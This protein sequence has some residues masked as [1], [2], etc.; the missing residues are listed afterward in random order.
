MKKKFLIP[1]AS[2]LLSASLGSGCYYDVESEL[3]GMNCDTATVSYGTTVNTIINSYGCLSCHSG[4]SP[5]GNIG[6][7]TYPKI[8]IIAD[9]GKLVGSITHAS[10]F[11]PMPDG[12]AKMNQC[13][14]N[15]VKAWV[16]AGAPDN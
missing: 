1:A 7:E 3:Y 14:I 9:N 4:S 15:R 8:K 16:S 2:F 5:S 13:D 12:A 6:L 11:I 10:G